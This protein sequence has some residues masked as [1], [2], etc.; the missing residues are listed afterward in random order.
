MTAHPPN[1]DGVIRGIHWLTL[2]LIVA[3]Y[4][5]AWSAHSGLVGE[6]YLPVMQ[7]HR[8]LGLSVQALTVFRLVWRVFTRAPPLPEDLHPLQKLAARGNELLIYALLLAQ[9]VL[10]LLHTN[11]RG[12]RVEL[13]LLYSI[14]PVIGVDKPLARQLHDWHALAANALLIL[15]GLHAAAAL[16]HHFVR[17]DDVL[18]AMLPARLRD[19]GRAVF[20]LRRRTAQS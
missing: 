15:I 18:N 7:L 20:A 6:W 19:L 3:V 11:A 5:T 16:F 2:G 9:P 17:R 14:P 8:S 10:G 13:F 12:Q 4:G 1:Y